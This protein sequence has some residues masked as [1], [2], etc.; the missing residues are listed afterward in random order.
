MEKK[1]NEIE[2]SSNRLKEI[3]AKIEQITKYF[4]ECS[5]NLKQDEIKQS[6]ADGKVKVAT[7][8]DQFRKVDER[9]TFLNS[10]SKLTAEIA[11]KEK[12]REKREQE[13]RRVKSKH[14]DNLKKVFENPVE[15]N[16]RRSIQVAYENLR[17]QIKDLNKKENALKLKEQS[18]EIKRKNIKDDLTRS[19][20][21]LE[22]S[23]EKIYEKCHSTPFEDLL[24]KCKESV[25]KLQLE[26][27]AL[28]SAEAMYKRYDEEK[29]G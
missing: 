20:K 1:L 16:F 29:N 17:R 18:L 2:V 11:L 22:E 14:S 7:L 27:G 19:E 12:E 6:I 24:N 26:H 25:S 13:V 28:R 9:L 5:A 4:E 23:K 10:I 3:T 8:Q 15:S 21:E